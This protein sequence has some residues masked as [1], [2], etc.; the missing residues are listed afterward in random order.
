M[1]PAR[2]RSNAF[3]GIAAHPTPTGELA[4]SP[5]REDDDPARAG[6]R[7]GDARIV[8]EREADPHGRADDD[9]AGDGPED[10]ARE[11]AAAAVV[12]VRVAELAREVVLP[13]DLDLQHADAA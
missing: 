1:E 10:R 2:Q 11:P 4:S 6:L 9:P 7:I 13:C 8:R 3:D 5:E 12:V